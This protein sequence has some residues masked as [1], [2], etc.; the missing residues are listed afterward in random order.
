MNDDPKHAEKDKDPEDDRIAEMF[1]QIM[2][3]LD[4][5]EDTLRRMEM[6]L[7]GLG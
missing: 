7:A 6:R 5:I 3:R 2:G 4:A 1:T